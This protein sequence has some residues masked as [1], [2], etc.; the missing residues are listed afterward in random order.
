MRWTLPALVVL[1]L[2]GCAAPQ[3]AALRASVP[4]DSGQ[5]VA[6]RSV[7]A[8]QAIG[9][10]QPA[11]GLPLRA[12]VEG[13]PF[14]AQSE[15]QCGP[16]AL[17]MTL[18]AAGRPVELQRLVDAV[19]LPQRRGSLQA[20]MLAQPRRESMLSLPLDARLASM[21]RLVADGVPVL[22]F[23]NLGLSWS[24]IWHYAVLVGYDLPAGIVVLHSGTEASMPMSID[25]FERTWTR[26][27]SWSMVVVDPSRIPSAVDTMTALRAAVA[28]ERLDRA[29]ALHAYEALLARA[30]DERLVAFARAN[31][32]LADERPRA[33][34]DA[35]RALLARHPDFADAWNNLAH[36]LADAGDT[37]AAERAAERAVALGGRALPVYRQTAERMRRAAG[38]RP[39][40]SLAQ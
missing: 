2:A 32:L 6:G 39:A 24:P 20:E 11:A 26:A 23:Q 30:P 10:A 37:Q 7:E 35:Y 14:V 18:A 29:A 16:A 31:A 4:T 17:A 38:S 40:A 1:A 33:A 8:G 22:V 36:A 21:L 25:T 19:Y 3:S 12:A 28:L 15:Y 5:P 34:I 13:V 9:S 27:G